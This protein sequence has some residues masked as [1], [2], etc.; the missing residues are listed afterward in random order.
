MR[1]VWQTDKSHQKITTN[2]KKH[3]TGKYNH[4]TGEPLSCFY[5]TRMEQLKSSLYPCKLVEQLNYG[6]EITVQGS[7]YYWL[8]LSDVPCKL[9]TEILPLK[10]RFFSQAVV[11]PQMCST[12]LSARGERTKSFSFEFSLVHPAAG[13]PRISKACLRGHTIKNIP[14]SNNILGSLSSLPTQ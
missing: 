11:Q 13:G 8:I 6:N 5:Y 4:K 14:Y 7:S 2:N 10:A 3:T 1:S 9:P 12:D